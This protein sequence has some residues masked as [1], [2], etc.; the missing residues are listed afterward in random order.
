MTSRERDHVQEVRFQ[1]NRAKDRRT[2][3]VDAMSHLDM[4]VQP[5]GPDAHRRREV[6]RARRGSNSLQPLNPSQEN[7]VGLLAAASVDAGPYPAA[8]P[9]SHRG[10]SACPPSKP[11]RA[12]TNLEDTSALEQL[13]DRNSWVSSRS[14]AMA[15]PGIN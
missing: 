13:R 14:C 8:A 2:M 9:R 1:A 10:S 6:L 3:V 11:S 15:E 7:S 4:A 12:L 5:V